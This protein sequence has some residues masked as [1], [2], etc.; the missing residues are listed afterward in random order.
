MSIWPKL[1]IK[2]CFLALKNVTSAS[3]LKKIN[4]LILTK[5]KNIKNKIKNQ[6]S[7]E[8]RSKYV[9]N[10]NNKNINLDLRTQTQKFIIIK[11]KKNQ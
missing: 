3:K 2:K 6:K 9:L 4:L 5:L 10:K 7:H 11:K 8:L 1:I